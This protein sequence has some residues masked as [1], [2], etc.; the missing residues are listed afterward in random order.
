MENPASSATVVQNQRGPLIR[1]AFLC[2]IRDTIHRS[3]R[4]KR[5][6]SSLALSLV[7]LE[8]WILDIHEQLFHLNL[9]AEKL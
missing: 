8:S 3:V 2:E 1:H 5:G 6:R 4:W 7:M 9:I